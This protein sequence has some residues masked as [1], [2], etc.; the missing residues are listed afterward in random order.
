MLARDFTMQSTYRSSDANPSSLR[1]GLLIGA[2]MA[3]GLTGCGGWLAASAYDN[4]VILHDSIPTNMA[5]G[6]VLLNSYVKADTP[7]GAFAWAKC[8]WDVPNM[9][10]ALSLYLLGDNGQ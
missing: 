7:T 6:Y 3:V 8:S 4:K 5:K 1:F 9:P 10:E 2:T